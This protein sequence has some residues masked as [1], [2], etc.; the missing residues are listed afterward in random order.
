MK[1]IS[2]SVLFYMVCL[3]GSPAEESAFSPLSQKIDTVIKKH[4]IKK[5]HLGL[6]ISHSQKTLYELNSKKHFTPASLVKIP[7]ASALLTYLPPT[8]TFTTRF[9]AKKPVTSSTLEG[10]LY[11]KGGGDPEFVSES[12]W[13][14]VNNFYRTG[15]TN[16]KGHLIVD[17]SRFNPSPPPKNH[18]SYNAPTSALSMN[19]NTV[20]IYIKPAFATRLALSVVIDPSP[21][22]FNSVINQT[23][24]HPPEGGHN[25]SIKRSVTKNSK[26]SLHI[27]GYMPIGHK[28]I[29]I[30]RNI[31]N[32]ALWTGYNAVDFLNQRGIKIKGEV[33]KG[34][35]PD[36]AHLLAQWESPPLTHSL[37]KMMKYSNN[38]MT[39]MLV[40]NMAIE[41]KNNP[42]FIIKEKLQNQFQ[43]L[44]NPSTSALK[45]GLFLIKQH[46]KDLNIKDYRIKDPAGLDMKNKFTPQQLSVVLNHWLEHPLQAEFEASLP[47][48]GRD[49]TLK[50]RFPS[51]PPN[52]FIHAKTG[53]L[54]GV[55]GLAGFL[56][57]HNK[58]KLT[59]VF[60]FN[61][62]EKLK[63]K[64]ETLFEDLSLLLQREKTL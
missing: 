10:N 59:F 6:L 27:T 30:Y 13:N 46:L 61:G 37:Q 54:N 36:M 14:L 57:S 51:L 17:E 48:A 60:I 45:A 1:K 39:Q 43:K 50:N 44:K 23:T 18:F 49:G 3:W 20:N 7:T 52:S 33:K 2:L 58:K 40:K 42:H 47:L 16:I 32:P 28:E 35:T 9:L 25:L 19:W 4:G 41:V 31:L 12:L 63:P 64:A 8:L 24:T 34:I 38:Y 11:L 15:I 53:S 22:Y 21:L 56:K 62:P 26:E 5:N 29:L 55:T